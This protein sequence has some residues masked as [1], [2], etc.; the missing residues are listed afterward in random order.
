MAGYNTRYEKPPSAAVLMG[1]ARRLTRAG[2]NAA[3]T[4]WFIE[5]VCDVIDTTLKNRV[6]IATELVRSKVVLNISRPVTKTYWTRKVQI[7]TTKKVSNPVSNRQLQV[8]IH[9]LMSR[10]QSIIDRYKTASEG[11]AAF[12]QMLHTMS[13]NG[14]GSK[15]VF[16]TKTEHGVEISDRSKPGEYPKAD[17]VQLLKTIFTDVVEIEPRCWAGYVGTPL[18]Y[19]VVLELKMNR[20]FLLRTLNEERS[21][22]MRILSGPIKWQ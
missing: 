13:N 12:N 1:R 15:Q 21:K 6:K 19:G 10:K 11:E 20:S 4:E 14:G 2:E 18:M 22:V 17:T 5:N 3:R 9:D 7:G 8:D 16:K